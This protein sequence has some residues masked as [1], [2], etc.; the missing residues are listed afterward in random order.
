LIIR[1]NLCPFD[2]IFSSSQ[3][4]HVRCAS[5]VVPFLFLG[6]VVLAVDGVG[7]PV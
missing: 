2:E 1:V 4:V 6:V 7:R 5:I 3:F